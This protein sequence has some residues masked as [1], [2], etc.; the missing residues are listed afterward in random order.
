MIWARVTSFISFKSTAR[1]LICC[2]DHPPLSASVKRPEIL[3]HERERLSSVGQEPRR[4]PSPHRCTTNTQTETQN[5]KDAK[6]KLCSKQNNNKNND[7]DKEDQNDQHLSV[8]LLILLRLQR[9][10]HTSISAFINAKHFHANPGTDPVQ[11][12]SLTVNLSCV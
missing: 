8:F 2:F 10:W 3:S 11:M 7:Y 4:G 12:G 6:L 1:Q 9:Q 5:E